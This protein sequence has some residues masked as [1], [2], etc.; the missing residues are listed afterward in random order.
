MIHTKKYLFCFLIIFTFTQMESQTTAMSYNIRYDNKNDRENWWGNRKNELVQMLDYYHPNFIGIQ[1]GLNHQVK[2]I[3]QKIKQYTYIG[4]GRDNGKEKGEYTAIFYDSTKFE[5][6]TSNTFW[7]SETP[8]KVSIGWDASMERICTYGVF[9]NKNSN[10]IIYVFNAHF[11][12]RGK[13]SRKESAQ[14]ILK[15]II[16]LN[17]NKKRIIVMGDFNCIPDDEPILIFKSLLGDGKIKSKKGF[18]GPQGT[19]SGFDHLLIMEKRID[20]IF[21][22]NIE[23]LSYRHLDDRRKNNLCI[24]D[25]LPILIEIDN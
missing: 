18:Y 20:Y 14:L 17:I 11:D 23:V 12:H 7:L 2:F 21:T 19:F 24:S 25:H 5:L 16:E 4:V 3:D 9:K 13:E 22:K 10:A 15:K 6:L 8:D 1:E